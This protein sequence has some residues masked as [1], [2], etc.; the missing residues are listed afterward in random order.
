V[1]KGSN[2]WIRDQNFLCDEETV[3]TTITKLSSLLARL[4]L[5]RNIDSHFSLASGQMV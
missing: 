4:F 2:Q 3:V 1:W 5:K